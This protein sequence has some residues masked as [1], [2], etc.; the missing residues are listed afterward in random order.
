MIFK[1]KSITIKWFVLYLL[2]LM[3]PLVISVSVY[4][5]IENVLRNEIINSNERL[6]SQLQSEFDD[7]F[8][9]QKR[10]CSEL[11][12]DAA[13]EDMTISTTNEIRLWEN[14][15]K[16]LNLIK[17]LSVSNG[18]IDD[19]YVYL[20]NPNIAITPTS[21]I[22]GQT[23]Y[24]SQFDWGED[25]F[26]KWTDFLKEKHSSEF[27]VLDSFP[28]FGYKEKVICFI[29]SIPIANIQQEPKGV[30]VVGVKLNSITDVIEEMHKT[31]EVCITIID[32]NGKTI[33]SNSELDF[34]KIEI[35]AGESINKESN[36]ITCAASNINS[37]KYV[38]SVNE[39]KYWEQIRYVRIIMLLY[40]L[41]T[42]I[43]GVFLSAVFVKRN[44][45]PVQRLMNQ[46]KTKQ[47]E[48]SFEEDEYS[49]ILNE[50]I[51]TVEENDS[52]Q[53]ETKNQTEALKESFLRCLLTGDIRDE[54]SVYEAVEKFK[55]SF[56]SEKFMVIIFC[57]EDY[58]AL[59]PDEKDITLQERRKM[60]HLII[61]NVMEELVNTNHKGVVFN[62]GKF[63]TAIIS[64]N[65]LENAEKDIT[66]SMKNGIN[67]IEENFDIVIGCAMSGVHEY[68][69]RIPICYHE[70]NDAVATMSISG[71]YGVIKYS[72]I[73]SVSAGD[74]HNQIEKEIYLLNFVKNGDS[75]NAKKVI[76][77][78]IR[79]STEKTMMK[80]EYIRCLLFN[81]T[82]SIYNSAKEI[83]EENEAFSNMQYS[84]KLLKSENLPQLQA[85]MN[86]FLDEICVFFKN[87]AS[88]KVGIVPLVEQF[89]SENYYKQNFG[90]MEIGEYF[91][92]TP[93]YVSKIFKKEK[94]ELLADYIARVRV[95]NAKRLIKEGDYTLDTVATKVGYLN[96]KALARVFKKIEGILPSQYKQMQNN[97]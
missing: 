16:V 89:V 58:D 91:N 5:K 59:F 22:D 38:V 39:N 52:L 33:T 3:I 44:Y 27:I 1:K 75:E 96:A 19:I 79:E 82:G 51:K 42:V 24:H 49:V 56:C 65:D 57:I 66:E 63:P 8:Y 64:V 34:S 77:D 4:L 12:F 53:L 26:R 28:A 85:V 23:L 36:V 74:W 88:K 11:A 95:E 25:G 14:Q 2:L 62:N 68:F 84:E 73:K 46:L 29:Q 20:F 97:K 17:S 78:I 55:I 80:T 70:A 92:L 13:L 21:V 67:F 30:I 37:W 9:T 61:S 50:I 31:N 81:L 6:L 71:N 45:A 86:A 41:L 93:S 15:N 43:I 90:V 35:S 60:A 83:T 54:L 7:I 18:N 76:D 72:E 48:L 94:D 10:V 47:R 32:E 87:A 69:N 40:V